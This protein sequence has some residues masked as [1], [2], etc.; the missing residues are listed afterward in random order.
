ME[1]YVGTIKMSHI[2][3][4]FIITYILSILKGY[5]LKIIIFTKNHVI[6]KAI[7]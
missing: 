5:I 1:L 4:L 6:V 3:D 2:F 7:V